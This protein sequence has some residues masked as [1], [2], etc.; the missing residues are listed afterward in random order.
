MD[1]QRSDKIRSECKQLLI[2]RID[3]YAAFLREVCHRK[4]QVDAVDTFVT[5]CKRVFGL[6][7]GQQLDE[8]IKGLFEAS[9]VS[10]KLR[11]LQENPIIPCELSVTRSVLDKF[12]PDFLL[13]FQKRDKNAPIEFGKEDNPDAILKKV[14]ETRSRWY[15]HLAGRNAETDDSEDEEPPQP[16]Q[17]PQI[18]VSLRGKVYGLATDI[19]EYCRDDGM[20]FETKNS[21]MHQAREDLGLLP[22]DSLSQEVKSLSDVEFLRRKVEE[23]KRDLAKS[24]NKV[25][26]V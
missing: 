26:T 9:G 15:A 8:E 13:S 18:Q 7:E 19:D 21:W 2:D 5:E 20:N 24:R 22:G 4:E 25:S 11:R 6:G 1:S 12:D 16:K 3:E 10:S 17:R 14:P 23:L